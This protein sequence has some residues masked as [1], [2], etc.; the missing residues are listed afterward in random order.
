MPKRENKKHQTAVKYTESFE[1][2]L[3]AVTVSRLIPRSL[4]FLSIMEFA[5]ELAEEKKMRLEDVPAFLRGA[6]S[7]A[8]PSGALVHS[9]GPA[10]S[11]ANVS[12][13]E[14]RQRPT[15][16]KKSQAEQIRSKI[17]DKS[18]SSGKD[19]EETG[20]VAPKPGSDAPPQSTKGNADVAEELEAA[21][22]SP[23]GM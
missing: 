8:A 10:P 4:L 13:S 17:V 22:C 2:R 6:H 16:D 12:L 23:E 7:L 19:M 1:G 21:F 15:V 14:V 9:A 3:D 20:S 18:K 5:V 11:R